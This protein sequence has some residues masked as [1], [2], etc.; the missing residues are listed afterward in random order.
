MSFSTEW[1]RE[2]TLLCRGNEAVVRPSTTIVRQLIG[3]KKATPA[4]LEFLAITRT[5]ERPRVLDQE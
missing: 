2:R 4:V 1:R 3:S 5:G